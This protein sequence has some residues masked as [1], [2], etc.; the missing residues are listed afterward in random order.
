MSK[1]FLVPA[2]STRNGE[3]VTLI[4]TNFPMFFVSFLL[5]TKLQTFKPMPPHRHT[6][7]IEKFSLARHQEKLLYRKIAS[8]CVD[9]H[10][11]MCM[12]AY[13][14]LLYVYMCVYMC[15]FRVCLYMCMLCECVFPLYHNSCFFTEF[16][17][18]KLY[19]LG[20]HNNFKKEFV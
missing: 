15:D 5:V 18:R 8:V 16:Q 9:V 2:E 7:K 14:Q 1:M 4:L 19:N 13:V 6:L 12:C 3:R 11:F 17:C 20:P 10:I